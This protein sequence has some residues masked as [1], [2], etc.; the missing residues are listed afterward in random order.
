MRDVLVLG[1]GLH[2]YG[3][4]PEKDLISMGLEACL[5]AFEDS[6][7][8]WPDI[9]VGYCASGWQTAFTGHSIA[10]ALGTFGATMTNVENA[11]ASGS[12][13]FREAYMAIASGLADVA[14]AVGVDKLPEYRRAEGPD[15]SQR[16]KAP[17]PT[18]PMQ[19]FAARARQHMAEHG[20]TIDQLAMV[21]VK[22]HLNASHNPCAHFQTPVTVE[23]VH[24]ARMVA[25]P[26]TVL[27]CC[28]WDEG[29]AAVVLASASAAARFTDRP[30]PRVLAS[31]CTGLTGGDPLVEL[32]H[33]TAGKAYDMAGCGPEDLDLIEVHDAATIEEILYYEALGL[34]PMGEGGRLI[35]AGETG[36]AGKS[37]VNTSGGL[38]SMGHPI[39]PTGLGQ[40]A[41]LLWQMR[42]QAG[43]RQVPGEPRLGL[44][45]MVGA[46]GVCFVHILG[47]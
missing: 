45:H 34:C 29:A 15:G 28:P 39:G 21:S 17:E 11:S 33:L 2:R 46:G 8:A 12:S 1:A 35:E 36:L 27:H 37:P 10:S 30:S 23:E 42:G 5:R 26:L 47:L 24:R 22:S 6:V 38:I 31:A 18:G 3:M 25:D 16:V 41:E 19:G 40:I 13:A 14:I 20:T 32:T 44:A 7:V 43:R 9:E 4:H